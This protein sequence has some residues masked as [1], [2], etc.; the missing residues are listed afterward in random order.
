MRLTSGA[1]SQAGRAG[2]A[3]SSGTARAG[4]PS[5]TRARRTALWELGVAAPGVEVGEG[6]QLSLPLELPA[7]PALE[8]LAAWDA[9]VADYATTGLTLGPHPLALLRPGLHGCATTVD[10]ERLPHEAK[11]TV[12]GLVVA[13]QRP[14]TAKGIVFLLLED[15]FG[16][17]NLI[18]PPD[19]YERHRLL[20]RSEPLLLA[21]GRLEKLPIAGGALN[22]FVHGLRALSTPGERS[23]DVVPLRER[24]GEPGA[25]LVPLHAEEG[26]ARA[27]RGGGRRRGGAAG[28]RDPGRRRNGR[29]PRRGARGAELRGGEA[30]M[31]SDG[32]WPGTVRPIVGRPR[33]GSVQTSDPLRAA[34]REPRAGITQGMFQSVS[35]GRPNG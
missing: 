1:M 2:A 26:R 34:S 28:R 22:V 9:M 5:A 33:H 19:V 31:T 16:T 3:G 21:A 12:G 11:V 20:V 24:T 13:R 23:A 29:L 6:T 7:A 10:L 15:E 14:G 32:V 35:R 4:A 25:D 30:A 18:V 27:R 17:I 8:P